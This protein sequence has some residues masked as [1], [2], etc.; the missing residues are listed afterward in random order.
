MAYG[1][2]EAGFV[3]KPLAQIRIDINARQL[4]SPKIG[5]AQD[6]SDESPLGQMN[7][8]VAAEISEAWELASDVYASN[9]PEAAVGIPLDNVC[10]LTG[11]VRQAA[12]PSK[13]KDCVVNLDAGAVLPAG[14]TAAVD[15]RPDITFTTDVEVT[16]S[17]GVADDFEVDC[18]CTANGPIQVNAGT[19]TE[20][21]SGVTGWNSITN[22]SDSVLGR[23]VDN[24]L[25][26]RQRRVGQ[27]ALRGGSTVRALR[28]DILALDGVLSCKVLNNKTGAPD[29]NGLPAHSF[30]VL[31]DDGPVPSVDDDLIAQT[32]FDQEPAGIDS[33]GSTTGNAEDEFGETQT[34]RFSRVERKPVFITYELEVNLS[35]FPAD[36]IDQV[37]AAIALAGSAY[38]AGDTVVALYLR[39]QAFTVSGVIDVPTFTLG[40]TAS[41][42]GTGNLT[43]TARQ[44]ATFDTADFDGVVA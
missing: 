21:V 5:A 7:A 27:L 23:N 33:Y 36:G 41:P 38:D 10:S 16:N 31:L 39:A 8:A 42:V 6:V 3:I 13:L 40:Y 4:A 28:A 24:T 17:G 19:L 43:T 11:T 1:V 44:R 2:T 15:G 34:E 25:Q 37:N 20:L 29:A 18:T 32:I 30:E 12:A 9:D 35:A 22:P 26:L 14:S